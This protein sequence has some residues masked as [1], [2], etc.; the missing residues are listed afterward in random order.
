NIPPNEKCKLYFRAKKKDSRAVRFFFPVASG[1][2]VPKRARETRRIRSGCRKTEKY[3]DAFIPTR[4]M[5]REKKLLSYTVR[6]KCRFGT[7]VS[8]KV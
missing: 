3:S 4:Y 8:K 6:K 5:L 1:Q 2:V 7:P